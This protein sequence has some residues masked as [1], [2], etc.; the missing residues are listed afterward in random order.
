ME[1][2]A[3]MKSQLK[4]I[5]DLPEDPTKLEEKAMLFA[6]E[7]H[8]AIDHKRK[9]SKK[10]YIIHPAAVADIVR[11]V[12]HTPEMLAAAWLH[13][14]VE[15]TNATLQDIR[16]HFG[17]IVYELVEML[18]DVSKP[19]D[20]NRR[21]RKEMDR[22]HT[23]KASPEAQTIKL[24]DLI[25]NSKSIMANDP[26]FAVVFMREMRKLLKVL[27]EGSSALLERAH[28]IAHTRPSYNRR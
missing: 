2:Q 8:S 24:G 6:F 10:P 5:V 21:T 12:E 3:D 27:T 9:Y 28:D 19:E 23:A 18:T 13:D 11:E 14:T 1:H 20:G 4:E 17:K 26:D 15:D 25:H 7:K 22:Q 16:E